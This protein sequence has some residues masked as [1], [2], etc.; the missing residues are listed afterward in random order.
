MPAQRDVAVMCGSLREQSLTRK[1]A[2]AVALHAPQH[3][4]F[5]FVDIVV[6]LYNQDLDT[7][8]PPADWRRLREEIAPADAILFATPE[9]NRSV[10]GGLKN[11]IDVASRPSGKGVLNGKPA[12]ILSVT[13]GA[14]GAFGANHHLR[15]IATFLDMPMLQQPEMYI[16]NAGELFDKDGRLTREDA[17]TLFESFAAAFAD[18]IERHDKGTERGG[19]G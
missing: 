5:R 10:P 11:A 2:E 16:S 4:K 1:A 12:A 15:Q 9:Y 8:E 6:S 3:L 19:A 18:W 17:K 14:V 7:A 13:P